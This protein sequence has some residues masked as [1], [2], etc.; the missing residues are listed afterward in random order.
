MASRV[1]YLSQ[2]YPQFSQD[3][4]ALT[5]FLTKLKSRYG[6]AQLDEWQTFI[7]QQDVA[8]VVRSL[9]E[10]HYDPA[11][12]RSM[13]QQYLN[14]FQ[15]LELPDLSSASIDWAVQTLRAN[16]PL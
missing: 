10:I 3:L 16:P 7:H 8:A 4:P 14:Q 6:Q 13:K 12:G 5:E 9:L 15:Q 11:Y 1:S 2:H